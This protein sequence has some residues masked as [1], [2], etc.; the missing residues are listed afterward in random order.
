MTV[1]GWPDERSPFHEGEVAFQKKLGVH[2]RIERQGRKVIRD[3]MPE[4]HRAFY[5]KL[6]LFILGAV[7]KAG[8]PWA[9]ILAGN[10]GFMS[11]PDARSLHI[12]A[13]LAAGDPA[14]G[15]VTP[16]ALV[17]GLGLE[18]ETR[19]RNRMNG[20]I[21][22]MDEQHIEIA[23]DQAFGNCPQYIFT[24]RFR[25][26]RTTAPGAP[27][28]L[29][30]LDDRAR[31]IIAAANTLFIATAAPAGEDAQVQGADVSHRGGKSGFV[32][33]GDDGELLI[34]DFVGNFHFNTIGNLLL[35]PKAG[36]VFPDF[37]T[38]DLLT[39]TGRAE[40]VDDDPHI[41]A[42]R[43]A[44]RLVKFTIEHGVY[45]PGGLPIAWE[46]G[47]ASPNST[48]TG[49]WEEA[50]ATL[51]AESARNKR[52]PFRIARIEDESAVIRSF[53]LE[54]ADNGAL[55]Q[56]KAGQYLPICVQTKE[57][58]PP[59]TRTYTLSMAP[60]D[61]AY[62][63]SV[64]RERA[65]QTGHD[66]GVVSTFL[67]EN[68]AVGDIVM[69][70]SPR[71]VFTIDASATRPAV[72][73]SAGVGVTPMV[74]MFKHLA[75]EGLRTRRTRPAWFVHAARSS[76]ERAFFGEVMEI[77]NQSD[78]LNAFWLLETVG[79][80]DIP[81]ENFNAEGFVNVDRLKALLPFDDYDFYLCGPP[82]FM[83]SL[84]DGLRGLD[85]SDKR[86]FAETF[87]PASLKR[88][89]DGPDAEEFAP[90]PAAE[91]ASVRFEA[92]GVS[93]EWSRDDGALLDFAEA[94]GLA[95]PFGCR[96]GA[97]GSCAARI[98]KGAVA[99]L[100]KPATPPGEG[101]ALTCCAVPA[102]GVDELVLEI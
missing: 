49:S 96:S 102:K 6:P 10:P 48:V 64:K 32:R 41:A 92:S 80:G 34:P 29:R 68:C 75:A 97:C 99:Y 90:E 37:A 19:R 38:G 95:P 62:R 4:Q 40:V 69:A 45:L 53:Y 83:Q 33:V 65:R 71:G 2:E 61:N 98:V 7:D 3:F 21:R 93:A 72:L 47:E 76:A 74:A 26:T 14:L 28:P 31:K 84:Y 70:H 91:K 22:R 87:G 85:V 51:A 52:R 39:L 8:Q 77:A 57:C 60:A 27:R 89:P 94:Q 12:N 56:F 43:G 100:N 101:E 18:F 59:L 88:R 50:D 13:R 30:T 82:A 35:N 79:E 63:I 24:R 25:E 20:R 46:G 16:G 73:I 81:G 1:P 78:A 42:F 55:V 36:I 15:G 86:I 17:G 66:D 23:V 9:T 54:P 67:H 44:E 5:E 58:G 11:A